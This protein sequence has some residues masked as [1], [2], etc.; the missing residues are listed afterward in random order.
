MDPRY[1][2]VGAGAGHNTNNGYTMHHFWTMN[3]GGVWGVT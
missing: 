2:H 1:T 3:V